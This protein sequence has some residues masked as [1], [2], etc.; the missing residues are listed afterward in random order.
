MNTKSLSSFV[1]CR[2]VIASYIGDSLNNFKSF[3]WLPSYSI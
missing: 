1:D 3:C 2:L